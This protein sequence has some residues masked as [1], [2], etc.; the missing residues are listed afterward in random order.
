[1]RAPTATGL[2]SLA[3]AG[4]ALVAAGPATATITHSY[5]ATGRVSVS[6]TGA[7]VT[8]AVT[9]VTPMSSDGRYVFFDTTTALEPDDTN[10]AP[11]VYR[12]DRLGSTTRRVSLT[13]AD[14]PIPGG[15]QVCGSSRNGRY[16]GFVADLT[17]TDQIHLRDL[18]EG[19]TEI[20]SVSSAEVPS[21]QISG[22]G[23]GA[24]WACP[25]SDDGRYVAFESRG[26]NLAAA[27]TDA[28]RDIFRRDRQTG[29][30]ELISVSSASVAADAGSGGV[31]MS[32]DGS[33]LAFSSSATNLVPND[34]NATSDIFVRV[35][36]ISTTTRASVKPGGGQ[37]GGPSAG[38][39]LS[40]DG[41][42]LA[43]GSYA[44]DLVVPDTNASPD[45]FVRNRSTGAVVRAS[46]NSAEV[47]AD[48]GSAD[49]HVSDDGRY[50]AFTST[51]ANLGASN[52]DHDDLVY[53]RDTIAGTTILVSDTAAIGAPARSSYGNGISA[54]GSAVSFVSE[55]TSL[56]RN[57]TNGVQDAFVRDGFVVLNPFVGQD[58]LIAQ[59]YL[60]FAG[61]APTTAEVLEWKLRL[62]KG[63]APPEE[64]VD[65][66][67]HDAP[68]ATKRAPLIRLYWAFFLR[69]PDTNGMNYWAKQLTNGKK[70]AAVAK[71]FSQSS[72]FQNKYGAKT[73]E[74]FVT[75]IYQNIFERD[76]DP[77]GLAYWTAK[78]DA[79]TKT[80]GDVMANFSESGEGKRFLQP[81]VDTVLIH[82]GMLLTMPSKTDLAAAITSMRA[83]SPPEELVRTI[84]DGAAYTARITP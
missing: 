31:A 37:I 77:G 68:W 81:Q 64:V 65:A 1:M 9:T 11:D 33:V 51:G 27:D 67:A 24:D 13:D 54:D 60:D 49:P 62:T 55:V 14:G 71:Q 28:D 22:S 75:L 15:G 73:N 76:P 47:L 41:S 83:G 2:I 79:K 40:A 8:G 26:T 38:A 21:A 3:L 20:I 6:S 43:F 29:T 18:V 84:F 61:R 39:S 72:E 74:Q 69:A 45:V 36:S 19:T 82:L 66:L 50:V 7:Q 25:A 35:P 70:L 30:T 53:R 46:V 56:V 48:G 10:G 42:F 63:E 32:A 17:G 52:P 12:R 23:I 44:T 16:V 57:D 80:R 4:S 5:T 59:Q 78:L 58:S 34:T